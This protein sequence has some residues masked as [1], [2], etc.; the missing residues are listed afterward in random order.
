MRTTRAWHLR[1]LVWRVR[2][3]G[4][5]MARPLSRVLS[6]FDPPSK[7]IL[8]LGCPRS[9]TSLLL[10]GLLRSPE[11]RSVQSEGHILWDEFHHPRDREWDSDA[12]GAD[13][14]T[15]REREYV[16]CA[17]RLFVRKRRF[18]D[19]TPESCLRIPYLDVLFPDAVFVFLRRRAAANVSSLMD[20]W[21]ARPRFVKYRLP[22]QL[23][24]LGP[25]SGARWS[26][27]LV[28]GWREL[29]RAPLEEICARQYAACNEA[30]LEARSAIDSSRWIDVAYEDLVQSP[31]EELRSLYR[32]LGLDFTQEATRY[33]LTLEENPA[34]TALTAPRAE[35]WQEQNREAVERILP[36][37]AETER[38]LDY[39]TE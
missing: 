35:K 14:V 15:A 4:P 38:R 18:V 7:P 13:D 2:R 39:L 37:V 6:T 28:P 11:L 22:E 31:L 27:V 19:K 8:V 1:R 5:R 33:A 30:V 25:L 36:L 16:Y 10:E 3:S 9:G 34:R 32:Q 21:R 23:T 26:F 24:G 29:R 20:A 12:L 17:I